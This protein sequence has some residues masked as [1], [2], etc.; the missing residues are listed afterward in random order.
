VSDLI[1]LVYVS[2]AKQKF[3]ASDV[4]D[5]LSKAR[6]SNK[7]GSITGMLLYD[8]QSFMQV[9][10]GERQEVLDLYARI[11]RD[12]R[13]DSLVHVFDKSIPKRQFPNW[14]MGY[15]DMSDEMQAEV[16]GL[17]DFFSSKSCLADVD[18][19]RALRILEVFAQGAKSL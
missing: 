9:I 18:Y 5:L 16:E 7:Q 1:Q 6:S 2:R 8:G 4:T 3:T 17:N 14:S 19:G 13:H 11:K 15:Q 10:E 12:P